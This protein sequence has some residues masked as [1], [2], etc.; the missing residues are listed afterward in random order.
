MI[1]ITDSEHS[2][3]LIRQKDTYD[4]NFRQ[5]FLMLTKQRTH[6]FNFRQ[7]FLMLIR[8]RTRMISIATNGVR[9]EKE[10]TC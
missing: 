1:S 6:D 7:G 10:R 3:M 2:L 5:G 8:Q 9:K 4:F